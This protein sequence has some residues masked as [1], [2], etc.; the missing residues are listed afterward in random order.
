MSV[1]KNLA[2]VLRAAHQVTGT[3]GDVPDR[4]KVNAFLADP[5][6]SDFKV[7][8]YVSRIPLSHF[9]AHSE[10]AFDKASLWQE[11]ETQCKA[12]SIPQPP[13]WNIDTTTGDIALWID[14]Q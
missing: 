14:D 2:A 1:R 3:Y 8:A 5:V 9:Y 13:K 7:Y 4:P 12:D 11:I 10:Q 6:H